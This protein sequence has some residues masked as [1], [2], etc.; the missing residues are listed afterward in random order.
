MHRDCT[1]HIVLSP[2]AGIRPQLLYTPPVCLLLPVPPS[3][4][5][6]PT[7]RVEIVDDQRRSLCNFEIKGWD[8]AF[9]DVKRACKRATGTKVSEQELFL[10]GKRVSNHDLLQTTCCT[11]TVTLVLFTTDRVCNCCGLL[12][13][14]GENLRACS[15]CMEA[16]YCS[17][18]CQREDWRDHKLECPKNAER[19]CRK[20]DQSRGSLTKH[21]TIWRPR[22]EPVD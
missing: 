7:W 17:K 15:L 3:A 22:S 6:G 16:W 2:Q 5:A 12:P 9:S 13:P 1:G 20:E 18:T 14:P 4:M 11:E 19:C 21:F 10:N 8:V